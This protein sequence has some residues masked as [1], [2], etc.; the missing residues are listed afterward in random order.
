MDRSARSSRSISKS[1]PDEDAEVPDERAVDSE[2]IG[3]DEF[4]EFRT[5]LDPTFAWEHNRE[6]AR[7]REEV[8]ER[9]K[10]PRVQLVDRLA[11][12]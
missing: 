5:T 8:G 10:G 11:A 6:M 4:E 12:G 2:S 9:G 3:L 1:F 7:A